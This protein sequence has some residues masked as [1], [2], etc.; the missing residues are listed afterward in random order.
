MGHLRDHMETCYCR[1]FLKYI[2]IQTESKTESPNNRWDSAP[3]RQ[4]SLA[5]KWNLQWQ[6]WVTSCWVVGQKDPEETPQNLRQLSRFLLGPH[7]LIVRPYCGKQHL[8]LSLNMEKCSWY[9]P[10]V[11]GPWRY[12]VCYQRRKVNTHLDRSP[13]SNSSEEIHWS[14]SSANVVAVTSHSL[15][16]FNASLWSETHAWP[17]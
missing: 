11:H 15:M 7:N 8:Y 6:E 14:S 9:L 16:R 2:H 1:S 10:S 4:P 12:S 5:T 13:A 3:T 17:C